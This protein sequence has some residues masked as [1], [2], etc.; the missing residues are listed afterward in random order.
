MRCTV[1]AVDQDDEAFAWKNRAAGRRATT[2]RSCKATQQR[3]WYEA[4]RTRHVAN[5][6][7]RGATQMAI[8]RAYIREAKDRPCA[9][10]SIRYPWYVMDFDHVRGKKVSDISR[11]VARRATLAAVK[12]EVAKCEVVCS[13]CHRARTYERTG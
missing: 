5:V 10:C 11:M 13:N 12:A 3:A 9:D 7:A 6:A 8:V 4:N 1:C 2:C